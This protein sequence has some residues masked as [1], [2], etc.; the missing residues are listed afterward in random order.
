[1]PKRILAT[2]EI[3]LSPLGLSTK[4]NNQVFPT[5]NWDSLKQFLQQFQPQDKDMPQDSGRAPEV[6][7]LQAQETDRILQNVQMEREGSLWWFPDSN[8]KSGFRKVSGLELQ[9]IISRTREDYLIYKDGDKIKNQK[10]ASEFGFAVPTPV[11]RGAQTVSAQRT[12]RVITTDDNFK[13]EKIDKRS[14]EELALEMLPDGDLFDLAKKN[15]INLPEDS[16]DRAYTIKALL[17][18]KVKI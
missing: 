3:T 16:F 7:G 13:E 1:M 12:Q 11:M 2:I 17:K 4:I 6:Y 9:S 15:K 5:R 10:P 18:A 14:P 8:E